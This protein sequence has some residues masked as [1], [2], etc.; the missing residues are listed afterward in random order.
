[1][2]LGNAAWGFRE[3]PLEEQLKITRDMGLDV[4]ELGIANAP[5][6][7]PLDADSADL[8][9][10]KALYKKYGVKLDCAATGNDFTTGTRDDVPKIKKVIDICSFLRVKYLRVFAGF[11]PVESVVGGR[12]NTM[13]ECLKE[14]CAYADEKGVTLTVETH[15]GVNAFDDG[16]VEHFLSTSADPTSLYK[17]M[18]EL[19]ETI[20]VNFDPANLWAVGVKHPEEVYNTLKDRIAVAHLKDF[21]EMESGHIKPAAC[22]ESDMDWDLILKAMSDFKGNALFEYENVEDIKE[23]LLRSYNYIKEK[24]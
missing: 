5:N 18:S 20:K 24:L 21:A 23:G 17:M 6:D 10:V 4:L 22:G 13:I 15:G 1:M 14:I 19:P 8:E 11:S 7:I 16:G 12:W 3:T 2:N 9:N